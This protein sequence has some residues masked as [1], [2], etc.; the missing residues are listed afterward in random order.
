[1][2]D[3]TPAPEPTDGPD[4][5]PAHA[6]ALEP[7]GHAVAD[8][9]AHEPGAS[10]PADVDLAALVGE[11]LAAVGSDADLAALVAGVEAE[12]DP[13]PPEPEPD[14]E[15][16]GAEPEPD[17][18]APR[19]EAGPDAEAGPEAEPALDPLSVAAA[20]PSEPAP[21]AA[22]RPSIRF[23]FGIAFLVGI[24]AASA[25][26]VG[27]M[28]AYDQHYAGRVLPG[29]R[30]GDVV[31]SGMTGDEAAA[32]LRSAYA[33]LSK[34][35]VVV[36][37]ADGDLTLDY[38]AL[39]R[40]P[41][42]A[43]MVDAALAVGHSGTAA[44][45]AVA[46]ARTALDGA[47]LQPSV[48][49]DASVVQAKVHAFAAGLDISPVEAAVTVDT[50]SAFVL[51]AG[52]VGRTADA[53]ATTSAIIDT[54][55]R[56]DAPATF[57]VD[58]PVVSIDPHVTTDEATAAQAA[59][60]Q[61]IADI[62]LVIGKDTYKIT[63]KQLRPLVSFAPNVS[64]GYQPVVDATG[65]AAILKRIAKQ[66]DRTP[67]EATYTTLGHTIIGV[68]PSR[69][70]RV[71]DQP[72]ALAEVQSVIAQRTNGLLVPAVQPT[73][74]ITP[75]RLTTAA[76]NAARGKMRLIKSWT[77]YFPI[78][79][80]N[81]FGA[82]IWLP[83]LAINGYVVAPHAKFDFWNAV[84]SVTA[85][86]GYKV[87][88]AIINGHTQEHGALGG[89]ICSCSTTL[90]NAAL[91]AG[92]QMGARANHFYYINRY[93]LGLDATVFISS[94][95]AKQTMSWTNDTD[96]PVLIRGMKIRKGSTGY[97]R[98]EL[99]SVP[100]GRTVSFSKPIVKNFQSASDIVQYTS[101]LAP[102]VRQRVEFPVDGMQV[103][104]TRTV[105]DR[106]GK[107]IHKETY[108]SNYA[109]VTGIT[110]VGKAAAP[111]N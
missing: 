45:R 20:A 49:F 10:V 92:F 38:A 58:L 87:G 97:V 48:T 47:T 34:G 82:N 63:T 109:R 39:G 85:A 46:A 2:T 74:A 16:P 41:D 76:A 72:A 65:L 110:L 3:E 5:D 93:P 57:R 61:V 106:N 56:I 107:V 102:G 99:Y 104:V 26:G 12:P 30:V 80:H 15:A 60:A 52:S 86:K 83:A 21:S 62:H 90:F 98:F 43:A 29:V 36:H 8:A 103:W 53:T 108:Y 69:D 42:I 75:P 96:Y 31:L 22:S 25:I 70:G 13:Q 17:A 4:V 18:E 14:A 73:V 40:R 89:G 101:S 23:R 33:G 55:R 67:L 111:V 24:I 77:T 1:M 66:V 100:N 7:V 32:A 78:V 59:A 51:K 54:L 27:A 50:T 84:G 37:G 88:G 9:A 35:F 91:R 105:R 94:G 68:V 64:G 19:A 11:A 44:D 95:G 6:D 71:L 79:Q 81:G 28:Y